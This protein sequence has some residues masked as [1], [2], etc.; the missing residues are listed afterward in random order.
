MS[1]V[2]SGFQLKARDNSRTPVQWTKEKPSGGF[3]SS[4]DTW[5]RVNPDFEFCNVE[6]QVDDDTSVLAF[7]KQALQVRKQYPVLVSK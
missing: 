3:S 6:A 4:A 5:M 2:L 1:D 7:W